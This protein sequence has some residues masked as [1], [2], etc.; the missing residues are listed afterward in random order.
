MSKNTIGINNGRLDSILNWREPRS[1]AEASSRLS[2]LMYYEHQALWLKRIAFPL[3]MMVKAGTFKWGKA[4]SHAWHDLL[5]LMGLAIKNSI[6]NPDYPLLLL[7]DTSAVETA[8]F[9]MQWS[10]VTVTAKLAA[11]W[12]IMFSR[13]AKSFLVLGNVYLQNLSC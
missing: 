1:V 3:F 9:V 7:V 8:A 4:E 12:L 6:F 10:P 13:L 11:Q 2:S 5:F